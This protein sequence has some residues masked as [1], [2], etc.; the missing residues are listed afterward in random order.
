MISTWDGTVSVV[1]IDRRE[2]RNALT[3]QMLRSLPGLVAGA[4][5]D[6]ATAVV[7]TGGQECFSAGVDVGELGHGAADAEIDDEIAA[8]TAAIRSLSVPVIAAIEGAC[9]GAA[10]EIALTCDIR[11]AARDSAFGIPAARLGILYR[12]EGIRDLVSIIGRPTAMRLLVLGERMSGEQ[13]AEAGFV[14]HLTE[15]G[16]TVERALRLAHLVDDSVSEA[17]AVT[18]QLVIE[19]SASSLSL[20]GF[21]ERRRAL[22]ES[23][24]RRAAVTAIQRELGRHGNG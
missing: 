21:E 18:R 7:L 1:R 19:A 4:V 3:R 15:P 11:V 6:G 23:D 10:V 13:A 20:S 12:P 24:A 17:V 8:L 2:K 5:R 9:F 16:A 22:L 14:S